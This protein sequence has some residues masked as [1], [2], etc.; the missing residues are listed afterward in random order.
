[1]PECSAFGGLLLEDL[2]RVCSA[3]VFLC[4]IYPVPVYCLQNTQSMESPR[5]IFHCCPL[6]HCQQSVLQHMQKLGLIQGHKE[7]FLNSWWSQFS[8]GMR[9]CNNPL[10]NMLGHSCFCGFGV[11][12]T[13]LFFFSWML[14]FDTQHHPSAWPPGPI[15]STHP[16]MI[17]SDLIAHK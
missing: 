17:Y 8:W 12:I 4:F 3:V 10:G 7:K 5:V 2:F 11:G 6:L 9:A 1:M 14:V 15:G 16:V 13:V